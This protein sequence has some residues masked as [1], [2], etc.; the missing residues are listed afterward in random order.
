MNL[1]I[2]F[3]STLVFGSMIQEMHGF[4]GICR[5]F[6]EILPKIYEAENQRSNGNGGS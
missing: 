6:E 4:R 1:I 3:S 5:K 2:L